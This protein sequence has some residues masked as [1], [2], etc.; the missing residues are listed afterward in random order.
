[1]DSKSRFWKGV[2]VGALVTAFAGLVVIGAASGMMMFGRKVMPPVNTEM[3]EAGSGDEDGQKLDY[4][5][6]DGKLQLLEGLVSETFLFDQD[7]EQMENGIYKGLMDGLGDLYSTYYTP[8]EF[9]I[10]MEDTSGVY[11]GIGAMISQDLK[12]GL[13]TVVRVFEGSPAAEAG[14][15]PGDV[16][17]K[18]NGEDITAMELDLVVKE[19]I[20][21]DEGSQV[22]VNVYRASQGEYVDL[23]MERRNIEVPTVEH[24]MLADQTGYVLITQFE[25]VTAAQFI[26]AVEDLENQGMK[27]MIIDVRSNPGG[28]L[29]SAV[30]IA[31]YILPEGTIVST[32]YKDGGT[33]EYLTKDKKLRVDSSRQEQFRDYP[34]LDEHEMNIPIAILVNENSASASEVLAGALRDYDKAVLV[35]TTTF[36][37]GIV[38]N[39]FPLADGSAVKVTV[40][41]YFTPNGFDLH[42]KGLEPDVEV[43]LD[44]EL[45]KKGS[46]SLEEDNQVQKAIETLNGQS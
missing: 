40:A 26:Q 12:T 21:G 3:V 31:A 10:L 7:L 9:N 36:G 45:I 13:M 17:N 23:T 16:L 37:K 38:Q 41:H 39:V 44:E 15:L 14:M 2:L 33:D 4:K 43:E 27:Q 19:H 28:V 1:M 25:E 5:K 6:I 22:T 46:F 42:G 29:D 11:C 34:V 30:S 35:G 24:S 20:K 18:V 32:K 8:E